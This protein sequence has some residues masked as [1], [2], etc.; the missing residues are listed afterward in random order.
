M[1]QKDKD[2]E[3]E[4]NKREFLEIV[5]TPAKLQKAC[6]DIDH[7]GSGRKA[8]NYVG[9]WVN[10]FKG[11]TPTMDRIIETY[12]TGEV[13]GGFVLSRSIDVVEGKDSRFFEGLYDRL[14]AMEDPREFSRGYVPNIAQE[15]DGTQVPHAQFKM[16]TLRNWHAKVAAI[17]RVTDE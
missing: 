14:A 6:D 1:T 2:A 8:E 17:G 16:Q 13:L 9:Y 4:K 3:H 12:M 11:D 15:L 7:S 10:Q 5:F